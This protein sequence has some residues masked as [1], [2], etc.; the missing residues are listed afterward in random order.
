MSTTRSD[1]KTPASSWPLVFTSA[2][3]GAAIAAVV[4]AT[5]GKTSSRSQQQQLLQTMLEQTLRQQQQEFVRQVHQGLSSQFQESMNSRVLEIQKTLLQPVAAAEQQLSGIYR[6][7]ATIKNSF[8]APKTR[9]SFGELQLESLIKDCMAPTQYEFQCTLSNHKRVDCIL[10][11]PSPIGKLAVDSKFPMDAFQ[12][13]LLLNNHEQQDNAATTA[14]VKQKFQASLKKHI[15]DI[16][17]KYIIEGETADYAI[18]F[19]P[20]E[21]LFLTIVG[22]CPEILGH[23]NAKRVYLACPTTLMALLA[24]LHGATRGLRLQEQTETMVRR[25]QQMATDVD[26]LVQRFE[27]AERSLE[28]TKTELGKMRTSIGKIRK[29]KAELDALGV[30]A[31][32]K[33]SSSTPAK[34]VKPSSTDE[35]NSAAV[36]AAPKLEEVTANDLRGAEVLNGLKSQKRSE[37]TT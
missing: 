21:A 2:V 18:M 12:Q 19:L 3:S 32:T 27:Q 23:A 17:T 37:E 5:R 15:L 20:S 7:V 29:H 1:E 33:S 8:H 10:H 30:F 4:M 34:V 9:G 22:E 14:A 11:L 26:R 36:V 25:V 13:L 6:D 16:E 35:K 28:K 24:Q 31:T